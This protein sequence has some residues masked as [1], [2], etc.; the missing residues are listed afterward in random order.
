[1]SPLTLYHNPRCSKSRQ[2][3]QLLEERGCD[4]H[5]RRYLDAPLSREELEAL[6]ARLDGDVADLVRT[7][8]SDWKALQLAT[9]SADD[10]LAALAAHPRLMQR[11][12][13]DRGDRAVIGRPPENIL[14]LIDAS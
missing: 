6:A 2:A 8:E 4:F 13:L 9:P 1:M 14:A 12:L 5:V 10:Y 11:P 7:Q 3:L